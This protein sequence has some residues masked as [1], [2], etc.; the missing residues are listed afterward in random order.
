ML[1]LRFNQFFSASILNANC[2]Y[3]N[4]SSIIK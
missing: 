1:L 3:T 4:I 2:G